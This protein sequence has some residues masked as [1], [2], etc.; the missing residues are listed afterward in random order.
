MTKPDYPPKRLRVET[1]PKREVP[2]EKESDTNWLYGT[3][4]P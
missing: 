2:K 4:M 3:W 1:P